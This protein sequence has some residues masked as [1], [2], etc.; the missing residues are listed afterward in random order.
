MKSM[1]QLFSLLILTLMTTC[2]FAQGK[3]AYKEVFW[4]EAGFKFMVPDD[5]KIKESDT[6]K[7]KMESEDYLIW[8]YAWSELDPM[9]DRL[10]DETVLKLTLPTKKLDE[11]TYKG[12]I[13]GFFESIEGVNDE[14]VTVYNILSNLESKVS[15][16][17][18][19]FDIAVFEFN[20]EIEKQI[21]VITASVQFVSPTAASSASAGKSTTAGTAK[22]VASTLLT[23]V[24]GEENIP[25]KKGFASGLLKSAAS[26][27][28]DL[29]PGGSVA[30]G[31]LSKFLQ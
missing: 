7:L 3:T 1:K 23:S 18:V 5:F 16:K 11:P 19:E 12:E 8:V 27:G 24:V 10:K 9:K 6:K 17:K 31:F 22:S 15:S 20:D 4:K 28:L 2:T 26:I 13:A 29:V 21:D 30:K 25:K 14:D